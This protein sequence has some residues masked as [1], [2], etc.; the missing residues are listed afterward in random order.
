M[1]KKILGLDLGT[2]NSAA[3]IYEGTKVTV[4]P[5]K[6]TGAMTTPSMVA[7]TNSGEILVGA[8]AARQRITNPKNTIYAVKRF[9]GKKFSE[10]QAEVK[11]VPYEVVAGPN[12]E[13]RIKVNGKLYSPEEI[14]AKILE[15]LKKDAE[16]YLGQEIKEAVVTVPAYFDAASKEATKNAG[17]IA[18][19]D[20]K[21]ILSEPTAACLSYGLEKKKTGKIAIADIGCG[22]SDL[23]IIDIADGV[24]EVLAINGDNHLGGWDLDNAVAKWMVDEFKKANGIDLSNDPMAMQRINEEAEKAKCAL[25]NTTSYSI[26]LPFI[27]ANASGPIH[28]QLEL[29]RAKLEQLIQPLV[30]RL[31]K[32]IAEILKDAGCTVDEVVLVGGSCRVPLI[33]QKIAKCF[34][35]E[36]NKNANLDTVVCEGAAIQGSILAGEHV[37]GDVLLLDVTPLDI[38]IETMGGIFTTLIEKNTTIPTKRAQV[39]STASDNQPAVTIRIATGNRKMFDDNKLL[40]NFNLD[41]IPPAPR[42][43]PQIE[44]TVDV[45]ANNIINVSAKDLGTQK[46]QHITITNGSGLSK[47][48]IERMKA[49]AEKYAEEDK[50]RAELINEKNAAEGVCFSIEKALKDNTDKATADEKKPVEDAIAK[51]REEVKGDDVDKIK[52]AV[53]ALNKAWEPIVKKIYPAGTTGNGQPQFTKEQMDEFMKNNPDMFKNGGPFGGTDGQATGSAS[54]DN[55]TVDAETV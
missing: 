53:E 47:D 36:P 31:E 34:G 26:S 20:V 40:G 1:S 13:C 45:D 50:K 51:V 12:D 9:M 32:P 52:S 15:K 7:F 3:A 44:V 16:A 54:N 46:E 22:T 30:D 48:E 14:S 35:K 8:A 42:G 21:R 28:L 25:S 24:F 49:D 38:G 18:G 43:V 29:N 6:D 55:G 17:T 5:A 11:A 4:I 39:F 10:V 33:Q 19:L 2:G 27:T 23:S 41:G 37:G